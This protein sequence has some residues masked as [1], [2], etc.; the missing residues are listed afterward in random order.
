[1]FKQF[2]NTPKLVK[3]AD[4]LLYCYLFCILILFHV[5]LKSNFA[6]WILQLNIIHWIIIEKL[7]V[8]NPFSKNMLISRVILTQEYIYIYNIYLKSF[9]I[10][11][12]L[13][14]IK[15]YG[16]LKCA[17]VVCTSL[18]RFFKLYTYYNVK[19]YV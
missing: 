4:I 7:Q 11:N 3:P 13:T 16:K 14:L 12:R 15:E 6:I 5:H 10:S 19:Y 18:I 9:F 2:Q 8:F 1:M 17:H